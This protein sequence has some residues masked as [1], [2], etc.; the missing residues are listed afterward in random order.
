MPTLGEPATQLQDALH[1]AARRQ[2]CA[3]GV[4][5]TMRK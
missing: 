4:K 1:L 2:P 3:S 5:K